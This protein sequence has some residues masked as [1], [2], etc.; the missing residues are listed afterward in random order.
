MQIPEFAFRAND[1]HLRYAY[2]SGYNIIISL[3][4]VVC[5]SVIETIHGYI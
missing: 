5:Q 1:S 3:Y 4:R 2:K